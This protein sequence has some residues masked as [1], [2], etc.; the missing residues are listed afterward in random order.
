VGKQFGWRSGFLQGVGE[1]GQAMCVQFAAW[2]LALVVCGAGDRHDP[3]LTQEPPISARSIRAT[4]LPAAASD[5]DNGLAACPA[6]IRMAS[7][8]S[9][10]GIID[11][12]CTASRVGRMPFN[13]FRH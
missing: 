7:N 13:P 1:H 12:L 4:R 3:Q 8:G 2:E 11:L 5:R 9:G 6:P 10:V